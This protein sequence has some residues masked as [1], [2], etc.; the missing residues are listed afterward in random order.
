MKITFQFQNKWKEMVLAQQ[1]IEAVGPR[2]KDVADAKN[3]HGFRR[4]LDTSM[5]ERYTDATN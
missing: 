1:V 4:K 3:L 5:E 2:T